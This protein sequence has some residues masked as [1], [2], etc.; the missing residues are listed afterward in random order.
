MQTK[1]VPYKGESEIKVT[2]QTDVTEMEQVVVTGIFTRKTESYT[3]AATTIKKEE[4]QKMGNQN[5]LQSLKSLDPAFH[6]IENND[7][8][9]DPNKAP[10]IQ[11]RGQQSMPD[12][13]GT[14]N[15]NPNQPL[16]ILDGFETDITTVYDLDM[17]RVETIVLLSGQWRSGHRNPSAE[18]RED[19][20]I[21]QRRSEPDDSRPDRL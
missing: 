4:L 11:L 10:Q 12:I 1:E 21:I 6:I 7:F 19:E 5:V 2:L 3:G 17:N 14:Y 16:F 9:S 18:S 20:D 15:G 8:G 13:K